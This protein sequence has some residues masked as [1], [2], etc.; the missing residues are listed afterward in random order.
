MFSKSVLVYLQDSS[1]YHLCSPAVGIFKPLLE[2]GYP[3]HSGTSVGTLDILG[4]PISLVLPAGYEGKITSKKNTLSH[5]AMAYGDLLF[6][7]ELT[8]QKKQVSKNYQEGL[9]IVHSPM[10]GIFYRRGAPNQPFFVNEGDIISLGTTLGL[11]E[12]MKSFNRISFQGDEQF[13]KGKVIQI[14]VDDQSEVEQN[15]PLFLI[16]PQTDKKS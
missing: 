15:T 4:Q 8:T 12:Q 9:W 10:A 5:Q 7:A 16:E 13:S 3:V 11:V 2:E 6:S 1:H 14:L